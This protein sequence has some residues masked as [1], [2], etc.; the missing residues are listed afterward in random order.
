MLAE[1][2]LGGGADAVTLLQLL[3][4]A[5][6]NPGALRGKPL[7]VILFLLQQAFRDQH[8]HID[9]FNA[10]LFE[11]S[12]HDFLDILPDGIAIRTVNENAL[13]GRIID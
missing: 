5:I 6:G 1:Q 4:A 10:D 12:I 9:I 2:G 11:L 8:G 3:T 13:D 7:N